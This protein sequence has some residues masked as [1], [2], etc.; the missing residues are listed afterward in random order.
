[1]TTQMIRIGEESEPI[2]LPIPVHPDEV[3]IE[4]PAP[5]PA[6]RGPR[7]SGGASMT[8]A[9]DPNAETQKVPDAPTTALAFR[10]WR[11]DGEALLSLNAPSKG[12]SPM[13]RY[14]AEPAGGWPQDH[15][16]VAR[17]ERSTPHENE[18]PGQECTCGIYAT[19]DLDVIGSYLSQAAPV[20]GVVEMGGRVIPATQGYRAAYARV[21]AILLID[22]ALTEDH[23]LLRR[24]AAA[25]RVPALVPH[26]TVPEEYRT[27]ITAGT[28]SD[29]ASQVEDWLREQE[30]DSGI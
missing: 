16:L 22:Q 28:S 26:S 19:T 24:V 25:Y 3:P 17:C 20:L 30:G 23:K 9:D 18:V 7:A 10:V 21:A 5:A 12:C 14:L 6:R 2:E 8:G 1:M 11:R 15:P 4:E 27:L 13:A 29:V